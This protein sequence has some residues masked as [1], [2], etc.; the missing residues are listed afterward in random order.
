MSGMP[1]SSRVA[2]APNSRMAINRPFVSNEQSNDKFGPKRET[3]KSNYT[4]NPKSSASPAFTQHASV[5]GP[6]MNKPS[7]ITPGAGSILAGN[8]TL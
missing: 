7:K 3:I 5:H 1:K 4:F 8:Q 2:N 6:F